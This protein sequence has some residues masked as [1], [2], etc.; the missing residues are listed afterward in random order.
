MIKEVENMDIYFKSEKGSLLALI[1]LLV[2]IMSLVML[3]MFS[4]TDN[5]LQL[6]T[7]VT[8]NIAYYSAISGIEYARNIPAADLTSIDPDNKFMLNVESKQYF[9]VAYDEKEN[10][11][12]SLG[13]Y[14]ER[15]YILK[16]DLDTNTYSKG[17]SL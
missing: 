13:S 2:F 5:K 1:L 6:E 15:D 3:V 16:F 11:I 14:N 9:R 17:E 7:R 4:E 12:S 10:I 8:D